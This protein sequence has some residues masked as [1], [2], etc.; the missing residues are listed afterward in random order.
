MGG[1][2]MSKHHH[3]EIITKKGVVKNNKTSRNAFVNAFWFL[4]LL[5]DLL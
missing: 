5:F 2:V 3:I 1:T 4:R